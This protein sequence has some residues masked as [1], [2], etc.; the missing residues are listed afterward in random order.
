MKIRPVGAK[1][2]QAGGQRD[3]QTDMSNLI[4]DFRSFAKVPKIHTRTHARTHA[5]NIPIRC[6]GVIR[7]HLNFIVILSSA[8]VTSAIF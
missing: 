4:V 6:Y 3:G 2:L 8:T 5:L 1:M 7:L